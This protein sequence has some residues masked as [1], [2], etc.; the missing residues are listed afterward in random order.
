M[1]Y[2][3]VMLHSNFIHSSDSHTLAHKHNGSSTKIYWHV[4]AYDGSVWISCR[5]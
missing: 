4:C 1:I 3:S 2:T 5:M